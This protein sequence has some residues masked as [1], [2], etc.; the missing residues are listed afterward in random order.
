MGW[1]S[2]PLFINNELNSEEVVAKLF[3]G[4]CLQ[5]PV[6]YRNVRKINTKLS[7]NMFYDLK[8]LSEATIQHVKAS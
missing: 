5:P 2:F 1:I 3:G 6:D 4:V 8:P 7:Y